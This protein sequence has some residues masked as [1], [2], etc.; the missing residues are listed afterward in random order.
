MLYGV[1]IQTVL[2]FDESHILN[3]GNIAR[4]HVINNFSK[5]N[6]L[7]SYLNFYQEL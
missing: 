4:N 6:M 2:N 3:L 7:N 1:E 5:K